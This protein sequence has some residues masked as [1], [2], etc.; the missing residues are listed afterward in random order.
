MPECAFCPNTPESLTGEH[1]WSDWI[2]RILRAKGCEI[3]YRTGRGDYRKQKRKT[4]DRK[5]PVVCADCNNK[6]MSRLENEHA[7]PALSDL[8]LQD[9]PI[10]LSPESL[11]SIALFAF[12]SMVVT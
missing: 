9:K 6:W 5:I 3:T 12:K 2:N 11:R 7:K 4:L 1:V 10:F 8:I